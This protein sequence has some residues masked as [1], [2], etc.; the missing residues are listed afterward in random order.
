MVFLIENCFH[1]LGFHIVNHLLENGYHIDGVD[2]INTGKKEHLSMFVGRNE[3]FRHVSSQRDKEYDATIGVYDRELIVKT[4]RPVTIKLPLVFGEW[5]PMNQEGM[6]SQ[7]EFIR[8]DTQQFASEGVY[9]DS[10]LKSLLQWLHSSDLPSTLEVK[11]SHDR[12]R[13]K[14][15]LENTVYIRNNRPIN[16][17]LN[18]VKHHYEMYKNIYELL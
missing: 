2:D 10:F 16:Q 6:Y 4:N 3:L 5:M 8:F 13:T 12:Q 1:W 18:T 14:I 11:S 7:H 17:S 15:K 9:I